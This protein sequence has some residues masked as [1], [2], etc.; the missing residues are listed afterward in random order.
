MVLEGS[1]PAAGLWNLPVG[2]LEK[3]ELLLDGAVRETKEETGFDVEV[4]RL[5]GVYHS[6][7]TSEDSYGVTFVF[8]GSVS[9]GSIA[10]SDDHPEVRFVS[11]SEIAEWVAGHRLRSADLVERILSDLDDGRMVPLD[12]IVAIDPRSAGQTR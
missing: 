8:A 2:K 11:R 9:S 12:S 5:I 7:N 3:G 4:D 6:L 1:G 10:T